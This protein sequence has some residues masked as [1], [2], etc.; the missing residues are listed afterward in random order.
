M[1][2]YRIAIYASVLLL[3]ACASSAPTKIGADTYYSSKTNTAGIFGD[4]GAVAGALMAEGNQFCASLNKEFELVTQ[5][6][7]QNIPGV[8]F[9]G[10]SITFKCVDKAGNPVMRPD[11][12]VSTIERR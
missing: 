4:V 7:T 5:N 3:T 10:A 1:N 11:N 8:R 6:V 9:G 12:G 2:N